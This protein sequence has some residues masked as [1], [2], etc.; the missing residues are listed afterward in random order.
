ML[1][2]NRSS[3]DEY[4]NYIGT[5][6]GAG[7]VPRE[8]WTDGSPGTFPPSSRD[9][10]WSLVKGHVSVSVPLPL[11]SHTGLSRRNSREETWLIVH[12]VTKIFVITVIYHNVGGLLQL[13]AFDKWRTTSL[14]NNSNTRCDLELIENKAIFLLWMRS[15][16]FSGFVSSEKQ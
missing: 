4:I 16:S 14:W 3:V 5:P 9:L 1:G 13:S 7:I 8:E 11:T 12:A 15:E 6:G 10:V 2:V